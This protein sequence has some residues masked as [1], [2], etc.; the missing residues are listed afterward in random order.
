[1]IDNQ[2]RIS[3]FIN[4]PGAI[5]HEPQADPSMRYEWT[6]RIE[7]SSVTDKDTGDVFRVQVTD[8]R[9]ETYIFRIIEGATGTPMYF[10]AEK[11]SVASATA[12]PRL[13]YVVP[14]AFT[15]VGARRK[16][17]SQSELSLEQLARFI[18]A[19]EYLSRGGNAFVVDA[20]LRAPVG[21]VSHRF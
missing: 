3:D 4:M 20:R 7:Q 14:N 8:P 13:L 11:C 18:N 16:V 12:E 1:M 15:G 17:F 6:N 2:K 5:V 10:D 9:E 19:H 21:R